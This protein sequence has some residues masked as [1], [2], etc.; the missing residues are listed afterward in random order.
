MKTY[1]YPTE[2]ELVQLLKRPL[3]DASQLNATVA[4]VL[5]DIK[6]QGD[7]AVRMYEEKFDHVA[8]QDLAVTEAEI[9]EAESMVSEELKVALQQAHD[10]IEKFH[11]SQKFQAEH[12]QV[13][14]GVECWQQSIPIQKV[15]LYIPGGTSFQY[16]SDVSYTSQDCR[17]RGNRALYPSCQRWQGESSYFSCCSYCRCK[18]NL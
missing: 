7:A 12:V 13:T 15:G 17:L 9:Q 14:D 6:S 11:A 18:Q 3:R 16:R 5:A 8:L 4:S 10:N 2:E 1:K